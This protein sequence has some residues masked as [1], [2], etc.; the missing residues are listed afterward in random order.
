MKKPRANESQEI[1]E[2]GTWGVDLTDIKII[3]KLQYLKY[4]GTGAE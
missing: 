1:S 3:L 2:E 4:D